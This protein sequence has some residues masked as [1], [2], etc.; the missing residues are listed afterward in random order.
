MIQNV[1]Q[2]LSSSDRYLVEHGNNDLHSTMNDDNDVL[3]SDMS[4]LCF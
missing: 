2:I 4:F 1:G 3:K